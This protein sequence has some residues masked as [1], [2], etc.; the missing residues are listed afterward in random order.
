[1]LVRNLREGLGF[2]LFEGQPYLWYSPVWYWCCAALPAGI[3]MELLAGLLSSLCVPVVYLLLRGKGATETRQV[4]VMAGLLMALSGPLLS[5]TCHNGPEAFALFLTLGALL[6]C[7]AGSRSWIALGA[8]LLFGVGLLARLT[9]V[10]TLPLFV[11]HLRDR[12]RALGFLSGMAVPLMVTW[13]RNHRI[14]TEYPFVFTWDGLATRS[15]DFNLFST[16]V[17]QMHPAV[18]EGLRTLHELVVPW[19][20]WIRGPQGIAWGLLLFMLCC[21]AGLILCRRWHLLA[22]GAITLLYFL[23]LDGSM[24]SNFF[25]I[26]LVLFPALFIAVA[27]TAGRLRSRGGRVGTVAGWG[28]LAAVLL[29]GAGMLVPPE[30]IP[31][32]LVTPPEGM[33]QEER[34]M[35][36][37]SFYHPESL[38]YRYPDKR[39]IGMPIDPEQFE[40]FHRLYEGYGTVLWHDFSVQEKLASHLIGAGGFRVVGKATN[41]YGR[42]YTL[43]RR[44]E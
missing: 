22:T 43:L 33:L 35:V 18:Q 5:F 40:E 24:S 13:W 20:E 7:R 42:E 8:G 44:R 9:F 41:A 3:P 39:F 21:L 2:T 12:R 10:F 23:V 19:P 25:R 34:Y 11:P 6:L 28:L 16:M 15:A 38:I 29:G 17:V 37:S 36:N 31:L 14:I 4:A 26:Y 27:V 30:P 1:V 32:E